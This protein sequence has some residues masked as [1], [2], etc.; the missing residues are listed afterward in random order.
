MFDALDENAPA[1][2]PEAPVMRTLAVFGVGAVAAV[3]AAYWK[4]KK[5]D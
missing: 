2:I 5:R 3:A 4:L 1:R